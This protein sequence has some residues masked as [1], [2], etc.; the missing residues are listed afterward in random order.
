MIRYFEISG[1][2]TCK[3]AVSYFLF[4][5]IYNFLSECGLN[6]IKIINLVRVKL[7]KKANN[8]FRTENT[9]GPDKETQD[10]YLLF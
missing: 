7:K 5:T 10:P 9:G 8:P 2:N 3:Q 6:L 1:L 4:N